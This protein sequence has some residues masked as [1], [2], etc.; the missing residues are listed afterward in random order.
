MDIDRSREVNVIWFCT[1]KNNKR[2]VAREVQPTLDEVGIK[3][4]NSGNEVHSNEVHKC[5]SFFI[6]LQVSQL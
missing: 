4:N 1:C 3:K 2:D 6:F 5:E